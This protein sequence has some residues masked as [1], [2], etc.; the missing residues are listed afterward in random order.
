M[1]LAVPAK[2][3]SLEGERAVVELNGVQQQAN[4]ALIADPAP[5]DYVLLHAGF[6]IQKWE[7]EDVAEWRNM[8]KKRDNYA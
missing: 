6:A 3:L 5:G 7:Q 1:C 2:I 4:V 8:M